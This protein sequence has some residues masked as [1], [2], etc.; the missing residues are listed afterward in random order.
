M[1]HFNL[2]VLARKGFESDTYTVPAINQKIDQPL[3]AGP[4][5]R[6]MGLMIEKSS[7]FFSD[8]GQ[9]I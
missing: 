6:K 2:S 3:E 4:S 8:L 5:Q 7:S 9:F 1:C